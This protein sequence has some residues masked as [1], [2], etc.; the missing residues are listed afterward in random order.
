MNTW[1]QCASPSRMLRR[2]FRLQPGCFLRLMHLPLPHTRLRLCCWM[3]MRLL[4]TRLLLLILLLLCLLLR[5][6]MWKSLLLLLLLVVHPQVMMRRSAAIR[7]ATGSPPRPHWQGQ[8]SGA[9]AAVVT[10]AAT[11]VAPVTLEEAMSSDHAEQ[12]REAMDDEMA[13]LHANQTLGA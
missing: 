13:S 7:C 3:V 1:E 10:P 12:W 2:L 4:M 9:M 6:L 8:G 11:V 5:R